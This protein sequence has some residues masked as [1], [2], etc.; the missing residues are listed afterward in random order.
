MQ[1]RI[2]KLV[3]GG[4]GLSR[5]D[6]EVLF[7]PFVL[8][9]ELVEAERTGARHQAERTELVEVL[10]RSPE[11]IKAHCRYF[12]RCGGCQYQHI[13]YEAQLK[14][15][16]EILVETLRRVG[17]VEFEADKIE[18]ESSEPWGYRN[19]AQFHFDQGRFGYK[20]MSSNK[21]VS[22]DSCPI[23]SP[24]IN[25]AI[26]VLNRLVRDRKWP[27]FLNS[28]EIFT[29]EKSVQ[30]NVLAS[31]KP[32]AKAFF[33]WLAK[34][35]PGTVG[36]A[37][38]YRVGDPVAGDEFKVSGMS[39]FQT[40]RFLLQR[41]AEIAVGKTSGTTAWDLYAGV[42]LFSVPLSRRF[43]KVTG[44][45]SGRAAAADLESNARRARVKIDV[46]QKQ[47]EQFL[48]AASKAPDFI[49]ADPPRAGLGRIAVARLLELRAKEL[50]IV[51]CDPATLARDLAVLGEIYAIDRVTLVDLFP[52]TFHMETVVG[53]KLK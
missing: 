47:T 6:G 53:L 14:V 43:E 27:A 18:V 1:L 19:R 48:T 22:I 42:G 46:E 40:N 25:E 12:E 5:A 20:E 17:K 24:K 11:R 31:E 52:Q 41:L 4:E 28:L 30:W 44:V 3:Y 21:L 49:L 7:T 38:E 16:R 23:S 29:D 26:T 50:A 13:S 33:E 8:P 15:K 32:I 36:G 45:E 35:V 37:L 2:E 34:E 39:F 51:S 10:E 9:G